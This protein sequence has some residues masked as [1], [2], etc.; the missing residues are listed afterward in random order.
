MMSNVY[1]FDTYFAKPLVEHK[2]F[3]TKTQS[4]KSVKLVKTPDTE[5]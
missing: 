1:N 5:Y 4:Q 3:A 2:Y